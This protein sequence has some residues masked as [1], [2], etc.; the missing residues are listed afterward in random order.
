[1][2]PG[3]PT[4]KSVDVSVYD[5]PT[6]QP[7]ADG[8]LAWASTTIVV[9]EVR[10]GGQTGL[11]WTYAGAGSATVVKEKLIECCVGA[12]PLDVPGVNERMA[13]ACRN[14]GRSGLVACA[15][16]AVDIA[17]WDLKA[18]LLEV[19]LTGLF[20]QARS[21]VPVYGSGGFTTYDEASTRAQLEQWVHGWR[22]PRVKIKIGESWG[23]D[24]RRDLARVAL[25]RHVVGDDVELY[26]DANGGY[27][28]K[29]AVRIGR[30]CHDDHGVTWLK[31]RC[32]QTTWPVSGR[33]GTTVGPMLPPGSTATASTTSL[34]WWAPTRSTACRST[35]PAAAATPYGCE[36]R[37]WRRPTTCRYRAIAPRTCT[38]MWPARCRTSATWSTSTTTTASRRRSL[39]E[40]CRPTVDISSP[41]RTGPGMA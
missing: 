38:P 19:P 37:A 8:T 14:L 9:V 22:I 3:Q 26:V 4:V 40:L 30:A 25:T 21:D 34:G 31:N 2:K 13:R 17:L 23:S 11:G 27:S 24:P 39:T 36:R 35:S 29:Q 41:E 10:G 12:S 5:V 6:D 20:G 16:S 32:P 1:M 15:I 33:Y 18:R 28:R 7:E